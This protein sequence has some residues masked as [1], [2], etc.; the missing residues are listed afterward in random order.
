MKKKYGAL[1]LFI[2]LLIFWVILSFKIDLSIVVIGFFVSLLV[3]LFNYDLVFCQGET[4]RFTFKLIYRVIKLFFVLVFNIAKSNIEVA[5]I[6]LSRKMK[7]DPGFVKI[8]NP[9]KK[10][11]NQALYANAITLTPGTL[12]VEMS[13]EE[14]VVHGLIKEHVK[15]L[16][17][18]SL[19]RVFIGLEA[20]EK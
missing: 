16:H 11:L 18:S 19:E 4:S 12:T 6:V 8:E 1:I 15:Q 3:V 5:K 9:L 2:L 17:G 13:E 14:I 20:D 10:E 7:I